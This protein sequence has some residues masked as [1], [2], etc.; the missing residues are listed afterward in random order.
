MNTPSSLI[1]VLEQQVSLEF[2]VLVGSRAINTAMP[3]S[4]WD[5]ALF[6]NPQLPWLERV[7]LTET[8]R[9]QLANALGENEAGIDLI[10]LA[11]TN[12]TMGAIVAE[13]GIPLTGENSTAWARFL[14]RIWRELEDHYWETSHAA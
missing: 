7:S 13:E 8:L 3:T 14:R 9:R 12:L 2:S 1:R 6:W 11:E 4:D 5:I 10:D